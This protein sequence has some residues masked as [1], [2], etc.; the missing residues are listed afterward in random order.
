MIGAEREQTERMLKAAGQ[1]G[2]TES[3]FKKQSGLK[4]SRT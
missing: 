1:Q 2:G 4:I 3:T